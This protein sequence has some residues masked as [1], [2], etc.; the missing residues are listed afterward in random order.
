MLRRKKSASG[1][2]ARRRRGDSPSPPRSRGSEVAIQAPPEFAP[3]NIEENSVYL[4][5]AIR[6][7]QYPFMST[8]F[9]NLVHELEDILSANQF[10]KD[11]MGGE[12]QFMNEGYYPTPDLNARMM[13]KYDVMPEDQ[14]PCSSTS[15]D[16][17]L[18]TRAASVPNE[19]EKEVEICLLPEDLEEDNFEEYPAYHL[20]TRFWTWCR[21][22]FMGKIDSQYLERFKEIILDQ[23]T[24]EALHRFFI[25]EPWKYRK[26]LALPSSSRRKSVAQS[27]ATKRVSLETTPQ[28]ASTSSARTSSNRKSSLSGYRIPNRR[29][30]E[31]EKESINNNN[32]I[33][34][35]IGSMVMTACRE[36]RESKSVPDTPMTTRKGR[37]RV[38]SREQSRDRERKFAK[39]EV[40]VEEDDEPNTCNGSANRISPRWHSPRQ[41][42]K[43]KIDE[44]FE[45]ME[46][47]HSSSNGM[48]NGH[49][50]HVSPKRK[51]GELRNGC[52]QKT[53][54]S[55][56]TCEEA[57]DPM[58]MTSDIEDFDAKAIGSRILNKL[59][60]G[61][62]LPESSKQIFEQMTLE[63]DE[64]GEESA[65]RVEMSEEGREEAEDHEVG[66]LAEEL[67]KLQM[68]LSEHMPVKKALFMLTWRR[69]KAHFAFFHTFDELRR[70]DYDLFKLGVNMY[71]DYPRKMPCTADMPVLKDS[72]KKRNYLARRHYSKMYRRQPK[73]RW[74]NA[75]VPAGRRVV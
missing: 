27:K 43:E 65:T 52:H 30:S 37:A 57:N 9:I 54:A 64:E 49:A 28:Q 45:R 16:A 71:K 24:L 22:T 13:P 51:N 25:N 48:T 44:E 17:Q 10:T 35:I 50:K 58:E 34:P 74:H 33:V 8:G 66:E 68:E 7:Q 53:A 40:D 75:H 5:K 56:R 31:K 15:S 60:E 12:M 1:R 18:S 55:R 21:K 19:E 32:K 73:Y 70:A 39:M 59:I 72:L 41:I 67:Q 14:A 62:I 63:N 36:L 6:G 69:A 47:G 42:K 46:N 61:G 4:T 3:Y 20:G 26:K 23:Y 11:F 2:S 29:N 38:A